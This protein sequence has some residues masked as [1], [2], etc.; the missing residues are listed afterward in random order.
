MLLRGNG[1]RAAQLVVEEDAGSD[2]R[3]L[4]PP[5]SQREQKRQWFD[6][7]RRQRLERQLSLIERFAHQPEL[8]L[9][10]IA[11]PAVEHLRT[12]TRGAGS[13]VAS[14]DERHL[15]PACRRV[16]RGTGADDP[17]ADDNDVELLAAEPRPGVFP[18]YRAQQRLAVDRD[19]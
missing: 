7:M 16:Q 5:M 19:R 15:Q 2:V 4:P 14:L 8:Q 17:A 12:A 10:E 13:E 18:L 6:Q 3:P 1:F 9:F 11:Q